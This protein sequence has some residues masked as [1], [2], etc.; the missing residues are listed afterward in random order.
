MKTL[1]I[2]LALLLSVAALGFS[3][4]SPRTQF[5]YRFV[6]P[7]D[8]KKANSLAADGWELVTVESKPMVGAGA[9]STFIFKRPKN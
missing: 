3:Y 6:V 9:I 5:E 1:L 4:Q 2:A 8:E 7:C